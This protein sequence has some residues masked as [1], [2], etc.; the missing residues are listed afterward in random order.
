MTEILDRAAEAVMREC[1][2]ESGIGPVLARQIARAVILELREPTDAMAN[3]GG[4][5]ANHS[6][7]ERPHPD[8]KHLAICVFREMIDAALK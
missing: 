4:Q 3:A 1:Y 7:C 5:M 6:G 2:D 8:D